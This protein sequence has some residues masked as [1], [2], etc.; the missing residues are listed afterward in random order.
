MNGGG[1]KRIS[2]ILLSAWPCACLG[3]EPEVSFRL[4]ETGAEEV[5]LIRYAGSDGGNGFESR[6]P[7]C[8][9]EAS[10]VGVSGTLPVWI[11][12]APEGVEP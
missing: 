2:T 6:A 5:S 3:P 4:R 12:H 1:S 9:Y 8:G 10:V 11:R 7:Q